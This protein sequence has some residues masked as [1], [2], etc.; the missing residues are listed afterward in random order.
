M[1][2]YAFEL[3]DASK[4]LCTIC[5]PFGNYRYNRLAMGVNQSPDIAQEIMEDL[6]CPLDEVD[7]YIDNVGV[8]NNSWNDHLHSLHKVLTILQDSNFT[9]NPLKCKWGVKETDWLGH[10]LTP[11]GLKTWKK[12]I[13]GLLDMQRPQTAKQLRSFLGAVNFYCDMYPRRS[14]ISAPLSRL[15]GTKGKIP[16]TSECQKSFDTIK[17]LL[18][19]EAFLAYLD[20]NLP[21]H[22][23]ADAS[24]LQLGAAIFQNG[25]PIAFYTCKLNAAHKNYTVGEKEL[26]SIVETLKEFCSMMYGSPQIHVYTDHKNNTFQKFQTQ[27]VLRWCLFWKILV[28]IF[29][30]SRVTPIP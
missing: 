28:F 13:Q 15:T 10:W 22:I 24:N 18:A 9:T 3:D 23:Y 29:I 30:T 14:H 2:Y 12:K 19:K 21:F 20:H 27:R 6:F 5:T 25:K 17:A 26:H 1:Q 8:Y 16:W 4:E 11:K 7:V